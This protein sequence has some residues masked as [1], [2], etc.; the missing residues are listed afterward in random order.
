M[1]RAA[2]LGAGLDDLLTRYGQAV[3]LER[4]AAVLSS[5]TV[6]IDRYVTASEQASLAAAGGEA[7]G[8]SIR[9]RGT[10]SFNVARGDLFTLGGIVYLVV[11]AHPADAYQRVAY[12]VA[13]QP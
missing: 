11:F 9:L 3:V 1:P 13:R 6:V 7:G 12:A 4:G 10:E 2:T 5:Q 8:A